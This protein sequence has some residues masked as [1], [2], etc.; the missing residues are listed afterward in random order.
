ML[1]SFCVLIGVVLETFRIMQICQAMK[2]KAD[3][4]TVEYMSEEMG[5]TIL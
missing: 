1:V 4:D 2:T 3:T 5:Q